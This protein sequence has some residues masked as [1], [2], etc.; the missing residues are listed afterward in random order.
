MLQTSNPEKKDDE[1]IT[2][3]LELMLSDNV[4][5]DMFYTVNNQYEKFLDHD[6]KS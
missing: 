3:Y 1:N 5:N 2:E 4:K 6:N